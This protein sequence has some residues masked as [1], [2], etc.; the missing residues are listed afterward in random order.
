LQ[1]EYIRAAEFVIDPNQWRVH[2]FGKRDGGKFSAPCQIRRTGRGVT[3]DNFSGAMID[4]SIFPKPSLFAPFPY[5]P[6]FCVNTLVS[7]SK[8][9]RGHGNVSPLYATDHN[10]ALHF[11][12][13]LAYDIKS[14]YNISHLISRFEHI[15]LLI[16]P[17]SDHFTDISESVELG[18]ALVRWLISFSPCSRLSSGFLVEER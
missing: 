16:V 18:E 10:G 15:M 4:A 12:K 2:D 9:G 1:L 13:L 8:W 7:T 11:P 3:H 6:Y 5:F 17:S 14:V